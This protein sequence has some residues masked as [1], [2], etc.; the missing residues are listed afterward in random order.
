M[1]RAGSQN[2]GL[3]NGAEGMVRGAGAS[4]ANGKNKLCSQAGE[5]SDYSGVGLI[6]NITRAYLRTPSVFCD[7]FFLFTFL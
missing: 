5:R 7:I 4:F 3:Q 1:E 6:F 2:E